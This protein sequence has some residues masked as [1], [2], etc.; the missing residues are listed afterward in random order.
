MTLTYTYGAFLSSGTN[1]LSRASACICFNP[2][3][4][5]LLLMTHLFVLWNKHEF[6][7]GCGVLWEWIN[8]RKL[9]AQNTFLNHSTPEKFQRSIDILVLR[10]L[11]KV[12]NWAKVG[13]FTRSL[14]LSGAD[15]DHSRSLWS[16]S[17]ASLHWETV[18]MVSSHLFRYKSIPSSNLQQLT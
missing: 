3:S 14:S 9:F 13:L 12:F 10:Y 7:C 15:P 11:W 2:L 17:T 4:G 8:S 16:L 5:C 18:M 1:N 6:C